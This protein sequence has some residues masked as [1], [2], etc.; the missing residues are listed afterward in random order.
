[1]AQNIN[2]TGLLQKVIK[3]LQEV[4]DFIF[5]PWMHR[6]YV[7]SLHRRVEYLERKVYEGVPNT[8]ERL[9]VLIQHWQNQFDLLQ[10]Q[11]KTQLDKLV[12]YDL[13]Q[14]VLE[15][16]KEQ[17]H[18][19]IQTIKPNIEDLVCE[20][21]KKKHLD[22][23]E[24][25][26]DLQA[27]QH[28]LQESLTQIQHLNDLLPHIEAQTAASLEAGHWLLAIREDLAQDLAKELLGR[29]NSQIKV[30]RTQ[31]SRYL[32]LL[33]SC[34]ENGIEPRLLY[35][36]IISHEQPSPEIYLEAFNLIKNRYIPEWEYSSHV[37]KKAAEELKKYFNY[38]T[39]YLVTVLL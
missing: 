8:E 32:K 2:K 35:Q 27:K 6:A 12:E 10:N 39:D 25:E 17:T 7:K 4:A 24:T 38:L 11:A 18:I 13:H 15:I 22:D 30:F 5:S 1:M 21:E 20:I 16:L 37:S 14:Q 31:L 29:Q 26:A 36:G 3:S 33:G 19:I 28:K 9:E 23:K 34:L